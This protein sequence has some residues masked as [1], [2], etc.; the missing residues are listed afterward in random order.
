M[1]PEGVNAPVQYGNGVKAYVVLLN[2]HFNLPFKKIQLFFSDLF[3]YPIK[4]STI[5]S[6]GEQCYKNLQESEIIIK[7]KI[8]ESQVTHTDESGVRVKGKLHWLHTAT[9]LLYT[10]LF[11]HEKRGMEALESEKSILGKF[12]GWLVHDCWSS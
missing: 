2:A 7:S 8:S 4:E 9:T 11:I 6:A 5:F 1:A 10:Y 12:T 3:G